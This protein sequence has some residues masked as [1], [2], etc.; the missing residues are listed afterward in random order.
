[1]FLLLQSGVPAFFRRGHSLTCFK[2]QMQ[3]R[4][5]QRVAAPYSIRYMNLSLETHLQ[6][7]SR[8]KTHSF[9]IKRG[10]DLSVITGHHKSSW[11]ERFKDQQTQAGRD[12]TRRLKHILVILTPHNSYGK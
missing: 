6:Q 8:N 11:D 10:N 2:F 1:M 5:C 4:D 3:I 9:G 7:G 12:H